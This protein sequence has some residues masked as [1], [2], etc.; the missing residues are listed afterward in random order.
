MIGGVSVQ[1][2]QLS[3]SSAP[4]CDSVGPWFGVTDKRPRMSVRCR[5][6]SLHRCEISGGSGHSGTRVVMA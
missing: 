6:A 1:T 3:G 4:F 2:S 5:V